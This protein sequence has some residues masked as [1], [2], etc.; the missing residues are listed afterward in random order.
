MTKK[1]KLDKHINKDVV[2]C[3]TTNH[4]VSNHMTQLLLQD[5][6]PFTRNWKRIPFYKRDAYQGA[7]QIC[8]ISINRN[9]YGKARRSLDK[10]D[11]RWRERLM[12]NVI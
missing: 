7:D 8:I 10:L 12:L 3:Q 2:L 1:P 6:I 4:R 9:E 5:S 11:R